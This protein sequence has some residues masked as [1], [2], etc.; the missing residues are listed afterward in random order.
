MDTEETWSGC[1]IRKLVKLYTIDNGG[2]TWPGSDASISGA[3]SNET[4]L[5]STGV[6]AS[7]LIW[8]TLNR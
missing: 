3:G 2:H 7:E 5:T 4:G 8:Q 1:A 6:E